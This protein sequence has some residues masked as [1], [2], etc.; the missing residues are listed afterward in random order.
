MTATATQKRLS[1][2]F[3]RIS[4]LS[5]SHRTAASELVPII[6][7]FA[8][9][10]DPLDAVRIFAAVIVEELERRPKQHT[11]LA[12]ALARGVLAREDLKQQ[13][14][15]SLSAEESRRLLGLSKESVLKRYRNGQLLGWR[16]ARQDAVRFPAWQFD[17]TRADALLTG[18][19]EVLSILRRS[20]ELDDWGR[21]LFFF[22]PRTSLGGKRP[23]DML[24]EGQVAPVVLAAQSCIE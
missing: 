15:G 24:R 12:S 18:T 14:G 19:S 17:L 7:R 8:A 21:I 13:E 5:K 11:G 20:K 16:E 6:D 10:F 22:N 4:E 9:K 3:F 23:L 2:S 1:G